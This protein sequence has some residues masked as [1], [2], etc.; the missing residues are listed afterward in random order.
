MRTIKEIMNSTDE[1]K[2]TVGEATVGTCV[3]T[4]AVTAAMAAPLGVG[5]GIYKVY[6]VVKTKIKKKKA[7]EKKTEEVK[8]N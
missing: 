4:L 1:T 8:E 2:L 7:E 5:Y 6:D 3:I